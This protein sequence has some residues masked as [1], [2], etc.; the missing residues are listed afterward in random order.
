MGLFD[1][2]RRQMGMDLPF[3]GGL[4]TPAYGVPAMPGQ[5]GGG[6]SYPPEPPSF[7]PEPPQAAAPPPVPTYQTEPF[8]RSYSEVVGHLK[9]EERVKLESYQRAHPG[10]DLQ[11]GLPPV[12]KAGGFRQF[13]A[14]LG[15]ATGPAY[16]G[17]TERGLEA[18]KQRIL[19]ALAQQEADE[20]AAETARKDADL[21][22]RQEDAPWQHA[23]TMRQWT[24]DPSFVA[25]DGGVPLGD[26]ARYAGLPA[27][28]GALGQA[29]L[30]REIAAGKEQAAKSKAEADAMVQRDKDLIPVKE[31]EARR[32]GPIEAQ[33][34]GRKKGAETAA[35]IDTKAGRLGKISQ[36]A[37]AQ[38]EPILSR[39]REIETFKKSLKD[40]EPNDKS[41]G[42]RIL[43]SLPKDDVQGRYD[44]LT[45]Y[46]DAVN[47]GQM[48]NL[49]SNPDALSKLM[50]ERKALGQQLARMEAARAPKAP[51]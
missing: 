46:K 40:V 3:G 47:A 23:N 11:Q 18:Y 1:L 41:A 13:M 42:E 43:R 31:D 16:T 7:E 8:Q 14:G 15:G 24:S 36:I 48:P 5:R 26:V 49:A 37:A 20:K 44:R 12:K 4:S 45:A 9:P 39:Q 34:A 22:L 32:L 51:E 30:S 10:T 27:P 35:D 19:M 6:L 21:K 2:Y 38:Q 29:T 17:E 25:P 33:N 28:T 50:V